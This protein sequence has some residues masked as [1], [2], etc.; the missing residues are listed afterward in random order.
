MKEAILKI[1]TKDD[2]PLLRGHFHQAFFFVIFGASTIIISKHYLGPYFFELL[3]YLLSLNAL[4]LISALY[5]RPNWSPKKRMWMRRLDHSAIFIL[6][7][8]TGTPILRLRT[9]DEMSNLLLSANWTIAFFGILFS[10]VWITAPKIINAA[11]YLGAGGF[12]F[13]FLKTFYNTMDPIEFFL[14]LGGGFVYILG[15]I[16]YA[17]KKPNLFKS[18]FGYHELFHVLVIVGS[19]LHLILV[20]NLY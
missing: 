20:L 17:S 12:W 9:P 13:I 8:G 18:V 6:I 1:Q 10:L 16:I 3:I 2:K 14:L 5:H 11:V 7:A 19:I 15:A 4:F